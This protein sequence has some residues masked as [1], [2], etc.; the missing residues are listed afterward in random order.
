MAASQASMRTE[1][2]RA[3]MPATASTPHTVDGT[4]SAENSS[5]E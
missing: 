2:Y 4:S 3:S 5:A 1:S